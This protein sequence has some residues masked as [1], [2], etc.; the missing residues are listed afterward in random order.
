MHQIFFLIKGCKNGN[1]TLAKLAIS[2]GVN[3]NSAESDG[4][5]KSA[6]ILGFNFALVK[7]TSVFSFWHFNSAISAGNTEIAKLLI[8]NTAIDLNLGDKNGNRALEF[9]TIRIINSKQ[10]L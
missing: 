10:K 3:V 9:G 4:D 5:F 6:L 7:L 2:G 1:L 8:N